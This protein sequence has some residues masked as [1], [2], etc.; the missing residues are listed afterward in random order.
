MTSSFPPSAAHV[1]PVRGRVVLYTRDAC[2][3]CDLARTEVARVCRPRGEAWVEVDVDS[4][5]SRD[6]GIHDRWTDLVPVVTVDGRHVAHYR[7]D[8][9][10]LA[11]A[12]SRPAG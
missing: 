7:V 3:L 6:Q 12:L 5:E 10:D 11:H 4:Q 8:P 1:V 2:H 9:G